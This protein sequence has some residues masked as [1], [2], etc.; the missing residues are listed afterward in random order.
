MVVRDVW[1]ATGKRKT[2]I[3]RV[4]IRPGSGTIT[5]NKRVASDYFTRKSLL[6]IVKQ[7]L[8]QVTQ[9]DKWDVDAS[10]LG[11][12]LSGQA[13]AL[14]HGIVRALVAADPENRPTLKRA[15]FLTRDARKKE[16]KKYG[17]PGA[18]KRFQY[19]KR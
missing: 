15:G 19:S 1:S 2:S 16:R 11:G 8:E 9:A 5:V 3:A 6:M 17:Q 13:E 12:G 4:R 14:R 10:I 7:P 18:R